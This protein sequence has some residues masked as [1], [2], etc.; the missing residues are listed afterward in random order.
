[1]GDLVVPLPGGERESWYESALLQ[2]HERACA[3][4]A[5]HALLARAHPDQRAGAIDA[6]W[7]PDRAAATMILR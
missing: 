7:K 1:M 3:E 2:T 5:A 6:I 4:V